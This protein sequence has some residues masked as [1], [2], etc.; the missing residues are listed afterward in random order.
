M[1]VC[2]VARASDLAQI[3]GVVGGSA[4]AKGADCDV[5]I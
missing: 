3:V 5:R 4:L 1:V 2:A